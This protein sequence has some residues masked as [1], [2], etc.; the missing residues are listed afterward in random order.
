MIQVIHRALNIL[1][2][3]ATRPDHI[4]SLGE[5]A[6]SLGLH[7]ATCSNILK[8]L[9]KRNYVE[10]LDQRGGYRL[11]TMALQLG[12]L[13]E[14]DHQ[15][16]AAAEPVLR[17]LTAEVNETSLLGV[18]RGNKR[19]TL[20]SAACD[21]DL[22]ARSRQV[23]TVYETATGRLLLAYREPGQRQ[24]FVEQIGLP[25]AEVWEQV[26]SADDL[27]RELAKIRRKELAI[28]RST[29]HVV[30]L[31]VPIRSGGQVVASV[32]MFLPQ[33]RFT[34]ARRSELIEG[35]RHAGAT[36]TRRLE[37]PVS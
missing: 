10:R 25:Q 9:A 4:Y 36:I 30:G 16:V 23:R 17:E 31:A 27:E 29:E 33:V 24:A 26:Q 5:L 1:E 35:L 3:L 15:L 18:V 28:T 6:D 20:A 21:R 37:E 13:A 32:S 34:A 19:V 22:Q 11:G 8:T 14:L 12:G 7:R 2:L